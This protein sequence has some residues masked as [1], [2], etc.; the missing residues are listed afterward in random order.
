MY[1]IMKKTNSFFRS[2][3]R[4]LV[5]MFI[6][7]IIIVALALSFGTTALIVWGICKCFNFVFTWKLAMGIWLI[8]ALISACVKPTSTSD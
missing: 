7:L 5:A 8:M 6:A 4:I 2:D 3:N 1:I